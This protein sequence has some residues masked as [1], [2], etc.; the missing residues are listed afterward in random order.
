MV[1]LQSSL[2][3]DV[4]LIPYLSWWICG[5]LANKQTVSIDTLPA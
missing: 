3:D 2:V 4:I 5:R 1:T